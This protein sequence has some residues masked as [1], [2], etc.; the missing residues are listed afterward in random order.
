MLIPNNDNKKEIL[1][2]MKETQEKRIEIFQRDDKEDSCSLNLIL[3]RYP[4]F[5]DYNGLLVN[6]SFLF[7][8][9]SS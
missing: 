3:N 4:R 9:A 5:L 2:L 7:N 8:F 1:Q 6:K